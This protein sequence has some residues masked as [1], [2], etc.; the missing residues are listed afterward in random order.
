MP[1]PAAPLQLAAWPPRGNVATLPI[2]GL[3]SMLIPDLCPRHRPPQFLVAVETQ[4]QLLVLGAFR[5]LPSVKETCGT[6]LVKTLHAIQR[7]APLCCAIGDARVEEL[8]RGLR[9]IWRR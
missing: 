9:P 5:E 6:D 1:A 8:A 2:F 3:P 4:L 7:C